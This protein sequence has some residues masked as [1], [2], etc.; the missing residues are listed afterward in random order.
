MF[1]L[2]ACSSFEPQPPAPSPATARASRPPAARTPRPSVPD[3]V[4]AA[5]NAAYDPGI[6]AAASENNV[7]F[8]ANGIHIDERGEQ[9]L[10]RH[11][12]QLKEKPR[13]VVILVGHAELASSPSYALAVVE[14]R[15]DSVAA[16]LQSLGV[17]KNQIRRASP[18][19]ERADASC[20]SVTC[21][22]RLRRVELIY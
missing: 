2:C 12:A 22:Q 3:P 20:S 7:Y 17:G 5:A 10:R 15:L 9:I 16:L 14:E 21:R 8:P 18:A 19:L 6:T 11:A 13:Q 4:P 1:A